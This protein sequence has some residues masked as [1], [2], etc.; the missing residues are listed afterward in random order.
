MVSKRFREVHR[1]NLARDVEER[2]GVPS[3]NRLETIGMRSD[4]TEFPMEISVAV[5]RQEGNRIFSTSIRDLSERDQAVTAIRESE[6]KSR[7]LASMSHELRTPLNSILGFAQLLDS[8]G[9]G[10]L[11]ERQQRYVGHIESSGRHLLA[12]I[13][14]VL[15][16]SKVAAG[17]MEVDIEDVELVPL[18]QQAVARVGP[19]A[20]VRPLEIVVDPAPSLWVRADRRRLLQVLL[21][22]LSNAIKFTPAGG[23]VKVSM[24]RSGT[25]IEIAVLD[26][27]IGIAADRCEWIFE[28]FTQV[29]AGA[30]DNQEGT[31]L[32]LALSR[33]LLTLM[34]GTISLRSEAGRGSVF[35]VCLPRA[36]ARRKRALHGASIPEEPAVLPSA[37]R[38][39]EVQLP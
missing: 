34:D 18:V 1:R 5:V 19:L 21:N 37:S 17:Q 22:L 12:L 10:R 31:G 11:N 4:G 36:V 24:A 25:E 3:A 20:D 14:D 23:L 15:D 8:A 28:E 29:Q 16:L 7:F 26:T 30:L 27:G 38:T 39:V 32:G 13:T 33:R 35:T 2:D 9:T 6:A